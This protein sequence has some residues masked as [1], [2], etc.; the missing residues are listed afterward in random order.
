ML[1]QSKSILKLEQNYFTIYTKLGQPNTEHLG[2][3][4]GVA[5]RSGT[6]RPRLMTMGG[7]DS[8]GGEVT[9]TGSRTAVG[10]RSPA[11]ARGQRRGQGEDKADNGRGEVAN[12]GPRTAA[13]ARSPV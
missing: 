1:I 10:V 8:G 9:G 2:L 12:A 4:D 5:G 11:R 6:E 13:K 7:E 3:E